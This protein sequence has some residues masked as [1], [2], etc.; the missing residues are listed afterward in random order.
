MSPVTARP[1]PLAVFGDLEGDLWGVVVGGER[2]RAAAARL[3]DAG[4]ELLP[5][6]LGLED[7]EVWVLTGSGC[8]LRI[9]LADPSSRSSDSHELEP[10]RVSGSVT[11]DGV[12]REFEI[13]GVRGSNFAA[14]QA[15]SVRLFA[16]WFAGGHEIGLLSTRPAGT[17]G[18]DHDSIEVIARGEQHPFVFDP[19][20]S[21]TYDEAGAPLRVGIEVWLGDDEDGELWPRRVAGAATGSRAASDGI[22]AYAFECV[23]RGEPGA[24][25][26]ALLQP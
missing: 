17:K 23:S 21:T 20:L 22:S 5:A 25:V 11:L 12:R 3:T 4:L 26:Y 9:E 8:D 2:P 6:E 13:G 16:A 19:R 7:D 15:D 10:C 24:G 1:T 18:H 14:D